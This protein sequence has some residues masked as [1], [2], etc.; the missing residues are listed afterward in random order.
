MFAKLTVRLFDAHV[1]YR[2]RQTSAGTFGVAGGQSATKRKCLYGTVW[3]KRR[4]DSRLD[5]GSG[6]LQR[7]TGSSRSC[8]SVLVAGA[9]IRSPGDEP[10][11]LNRRP[12]M[13]RPLLRLVLTIL[14]TADHQ[15]GPPETWGPSSVPLSD[16]IREWFPHSP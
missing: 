13:D 12:S 8:S 1:R 7:T 15:S 6:Q 11:S 9:T 5:A 2:S 14:Q 3:T 10:Q 4:E 16:Y